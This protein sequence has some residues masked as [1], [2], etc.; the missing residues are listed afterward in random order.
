M[1]PNT[2]AAICL[3][4]GGWLLFG[5][6]LPIPPGPNPVDPVEPIDVTPITEPGNRVLIVYESEEKSEYPQEQSLILNSGVIAEYLDEHCIKVDGHPE[7]RIWDK[8]VQ[9][10]NSDGPLVDQVWIDAMGIPR[11]SLPWLIVTNGKT[12]YN[13]VLPLTE[14][15]TLAIFRE[16]LE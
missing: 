15:E 7:Y 1:K 8:D 13:E 3:I 5:D 6:R 14:A 11:K 9:L 2:I 12:G 4:I 10:E 16:H